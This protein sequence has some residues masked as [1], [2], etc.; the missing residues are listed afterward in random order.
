[1]GILQ[2]IIEAIATLF[3][4]RQDISD[5]HKQQAYG[6]RWTKHRPRRISGYRRKRPRR[7][8]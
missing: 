6:R 3:G 7:A 1:M 2:T 8:R 4:A 5:H